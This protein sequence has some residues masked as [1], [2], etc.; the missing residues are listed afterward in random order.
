MAQQELDAGRAEGAAVV[1]VVR[2]SK[3]EPETQ[4]ESQFRENQF[5]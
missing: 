4:T 2:G 1:V 5:V 3:V